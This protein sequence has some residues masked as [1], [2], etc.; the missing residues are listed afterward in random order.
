MTY[1]FSNKLLWTELVS[2]MSLSDKEI[3]RRAQRYFSEDRFVASKSNL[4]RSL[5]KRLTQV[6][7]DSSFI[8]IAQRISDEIRENSD[9]KALESC[10]EKIRELGEEG[11][12][13]KE[14]PNNMV[15][16]WENLAVQLE[17][18]RTLENGDQVCFLYTYHR[19]SPPLSTDGIRALLYIVRAFLRE[20]KVND[21]RIVVLD[22]YKD[23][24]YEDSDFESNDKWIA[25]KIEAV[26]VRYAAA[27]QLCFDNDPPVPPSFPPTLPPTANPAPYPGKLL[28][29]DCKGSVKIRNDTQL[30]LQLK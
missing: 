30:S 24:S 26:L 18:H 20:Q 28:R 12:L 6:I 13:L 23:N 17:P 15:L 22:C 1:H 2:C 27:Y 10:I 25:K 8:D 3:S 29:I 21:F 19:Q 5:I 7:F 9:A 16:A 4:K 14:R 11:W